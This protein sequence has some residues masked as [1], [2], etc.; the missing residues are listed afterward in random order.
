VKVVGVKLTIVDCTI[1]VLPAI[2]VALVTVAVGTKGARPPLAG[3]QTWPPSCSCTAGSESIHA[4]IVAGGILLGCWMRRESAINDGHTV[5][6]CNGAS[7]DAQVLSASTMVAYW[8]DVYATYVVG[9]VLCRISN[10]PRDVRSP[11]T[12]ELRRLPK[13][14]VQQQDL[15]MP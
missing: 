8:M 6:N 1:L 5:G 7:V 12:A 3:S 11:L 9:Y 15:L 14:L 10:G 13:S 4:I 2:V